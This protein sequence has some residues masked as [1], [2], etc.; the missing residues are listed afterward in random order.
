MNKTIVGALIVLIALVA[1][2]VFL[3]PVQSSR[4]T[5][6]S[7]VVER[8]E[9]ADFGAA[10]KITVQRAEE[11]VEVKRAGDKWVVASSYSYPADGEKIEK[12]LKSLGEVEAGEQRGRSEKA[13]RKFEVDSKKGSTITIYGEGDKELGRLVVGANVPGGG[14]GTSR[15]FVRFGGDAT[16]YSAESDVRSTGGLYSVEGKNYLQKKLVDLSPDVQVESVRLVR[17]E[18]PDL[19]VERK[20]HEVAVEKPEGVDS[21]S[22]QEDSGEQEEPKKP[23]TK[24]EEFYVVVSGSESVTVEKSKEYTASGL[25]RTAKSLSIE[26]AVEP[27]DRADYGLDT[28]QLKAVVSYRQKSDDSAEMKSLEILFGNAKKDEK[29]ET[30][31]YY[32]VVDDE[33]HRDRIYLLQQYSFDSWNKEME[34]FL[35]EPPEVP[36]APAVP[37]APVVPEAPAL[38]VEQAAA[39]GENAAVDGGAGEESAAT[40]KEPK[41]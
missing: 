23:E 25:L 19:I 26:D 31:G 8:F 34:A 24:T 6:V 13:H 28:P 2:W 33:E 30:T 20:V 21:A 7:E 14:I 40:E 15:V 9:E 37:E 4:I 3:K 12:L 29:G 36:E 27:K 35:P 18:R 16:T 1:V 11:A 17:P 39:E 41:Q 22:A 32:V 10:R 5:V 38:E